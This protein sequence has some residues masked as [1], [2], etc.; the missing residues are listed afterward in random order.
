[1]DLNA[2]YRR[3]SLFPDPP[4]DVLPPQMLPSGRGVIPRPGAPSADP[5]VPVAPTADP[6]TGLDAL[7]DGTQAVF[8]TLSPLLQQRAVRPGEIVDYNRETFLDDLDATQAAG[9]SLVSRFVERPEE[10]FDLTS[11]LI[12]A[13]EDRRAAMMQAAQIGVDR[14]RAEAQERMRLHL[15]TQT[16]ADIAQLVSGSAIER[17]E[18]MQAAISARATAK[19]AESEMEAAGIREAATDRYKAKLAQVQ[20]QM[21]VARRNAGLDARQYDRDMVVQSG[22]G[23]ADSAADEAS[24]ANAADTLNL[25]GQAATA[26]ASQRQEQAQAQER[27]RQE[28]ARQRQ[29]QIQLRAQARADRAENRQAAAQA[30]QEAR[31]RRAEARAER[32]ARSGGAPSASPPVEFDISPLLADRQAIDAAL[33][34]PDLAPSDRRAL[35]RERRI[36]N[37]EIIGYQREG[38]VGRAPQALRPSQPAGIVNTWLSGDLAPTAPNYNYSGAADALL[39]GNGQERMTPAEIEELNSYR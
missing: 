22:L 7:G 39:R 26:S 28:A 23:A 14:A 29:F 32:A 8:E 20:E 21:R 24:R 30:A 38:G 36:L 3:R 18:T 4:T 6:V 34:V 17:P 1:M 27:A 19:G 2:L 12:P 31:A 37:K 5:P 9:R 13:Q 10:A 35:L 15:L 33:R 11:A 16:G 25:V